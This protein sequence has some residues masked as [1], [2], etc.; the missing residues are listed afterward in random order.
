VIQKNDANTV[1]VANNFRVATHTFGGSLIAHANMHF[2]GQVTRMR[3][4]SA[5]VLVVFAN[6]PT[7]LPALNR[8]VTTS[9]F[10]AYSLSATAKTLL[11]MDYYQF[12]A[13]NEFYIYSYTGVFEWVKY[14]H[15]VMPYFASRA[16]LDKSACTTSDIQSI[17]VLPGLHR[18]LI[19]GTDYVCL[20]SLV[21]S[22]PTLSIT[23]L[24]KWLT[25]PTS[26]TVQ[27]LMPEYKNTRLILYASEGIQV[28]NKDNLT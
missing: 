10:S 1:W 3:F 11:S 25:T 15:T 4:N 18:V 20:Y 28:I 12:D 13:S 24:Y 6:A 5:N 9:S 27:Y 2:G 26:N 21:W 7:G 16:S 22:S 19:K 8:I 17:D 14:T 23:F